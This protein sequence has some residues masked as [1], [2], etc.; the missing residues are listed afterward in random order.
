MHYHS[1]CP[2]TTRNDKAV[3]CSVETQD[4]GCNFDGK[5]PQ[6]KISET[7]TE[8]GTWEMADLAKAVADIFE[9]CSRQTKR[10]RPKYTDRTLN[11]HMGPTYDPKAVL[12]LLRQR[13]HYLLNCGGSVNAYIHIKK[14]ETE[15]EEEVELAKQAGQKK[16]P[17]K[18]FKT[19]LE[20]LKTIFPD[21]PTFVEEYMRG[22]RG[23]GDMTD[24]ELGRANQFILT[25]EAIQQKDDW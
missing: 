10:A 1:K 17:T 2:V 3:Q 21:I 14:L 5:V 19:E 8:T 6:D 15:L 9:E 7:G 16:T 24:R 23:V 13:K 12:K 22:L 18:N 11:E 4:F 25:A 20:L